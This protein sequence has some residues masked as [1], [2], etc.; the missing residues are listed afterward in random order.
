MLSLKV[1]TE[2]NRDYHWLVL[3]LEK[4]KQNVQEP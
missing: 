3:S 1:L 4:E 2:E